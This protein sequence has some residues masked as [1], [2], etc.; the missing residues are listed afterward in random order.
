MD[1]MDVESKVILKNG[2]KYELK[3]VQWRLGIKASFHGEGGT[4]YG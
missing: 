2:Q 1:L 3:K 4:Y